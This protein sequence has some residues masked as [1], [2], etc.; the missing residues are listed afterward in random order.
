MWEQCHSGR[1]GQCV[2]YIMNMNAGYSRISLDKLT[3]PGWIKIKI[4][5]TGVNWCEK[6]SLD[7]SNNTFC[8]FLFQHPAACP[9][10]AHASLFEEDCVSILTSQWG[11]EKGDD[12]GFSDCGAAL[13]PTCTEEISSSAEKPTW[14]TLTPHSSKAGH[15]VFPLHWDRLCI[16]SNTVGLAYVMPPFNICPPTHNPL[17]SALYTDSF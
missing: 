4:V 14:Q 16:Y 12:L 6:W 8:L 5:W 10:S 3:F 15:T 17:L 1:A 2:E 11:R 13:L 9:L 7:M